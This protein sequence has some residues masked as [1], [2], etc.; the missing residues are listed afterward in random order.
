MKNKKKYYFKSRD[1]TKNVFVKILKFKKYTFD[2]LKLE[3]PDLC[4]NFTEEYWNSVKELS[5]KDGFKQKDSAQKSII[6]EL[7]GVENLF[8]NLKTLKL[9]NE[10]TIKKSY[11]YGGYKKEY[12]EKYELYSFEIS[13]LLGNDIIFNRHKICYFIKGN[14]PSTNK[15]FYVYVDP[16]L[17]QREKDI[18]N[19]N[20]IEILCSTFKIPD[21]KT[22]HIDSI[23]RQGDVLLIKLKEPY[24]KELINYP[25]YR[26]ITLEEY[27]TKLIYET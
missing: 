6:F 23:Y 10:Q 24:K 4:S 26:D 8:N 20:I 7:L 15:P 17:I 13:E 3:N 25:R 18:E 16:F 5:Y 19:I 21:F 22:E 11:N 1:F 12:E 9:L 27:Y 2:K 14:C